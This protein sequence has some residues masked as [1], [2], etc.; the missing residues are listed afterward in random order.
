MHTNFW[1]KNMKGSN[2]SEK[3]RRGRE[4]NIKMDFTGECGMN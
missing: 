1:W 4:N 3:T 2:N